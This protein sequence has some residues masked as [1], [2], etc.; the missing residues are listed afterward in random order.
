M[1]AI[2]IRW[3][4]RVSQHR[5]TIR[6]AAHCF[7]PFP[8]ADCD[9][10]L[11]RLLYAQ[12]LCPTFVHKQLFSQPSSRSNVLFT[13]DYVQQTCSARCGENNLRPMRPLIVKQTHSASVCLSPDALIIYVFCL[14]KIGVHKF[15]CRTFT[16]RD[17]HYLYF[18]DSNFL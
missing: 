7:H 11:F 4:A 9:L 5:E 8:A 13:A 2:T 16:E 6:S 12:F 15:C 10:T 1:M 18:W 17:W 14:N 3:R